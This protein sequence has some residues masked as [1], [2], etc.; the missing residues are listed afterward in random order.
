M[1]SAVGSEGDFARAW[2]TLKARYLE[3]AATEGAELIETTKQELREQLRRA[4]L[5]L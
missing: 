3:R 4:G 2:P 1:L 5:T